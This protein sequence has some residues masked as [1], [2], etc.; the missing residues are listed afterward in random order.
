MPV[1]YADCLRMY[2]LFPYGDKSGNYGKR[3][4]EKIARMRRHPAPNRRV[5]GPISA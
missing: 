5:N 4:P 3:S 1:K 2:S